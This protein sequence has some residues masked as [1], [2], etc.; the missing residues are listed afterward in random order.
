VLNKFEVFKAFQFRHNKAVTGKM[1]RLRDTRPYESYPYDFPN[2]IVHVYVVDESSAEFPVGL[3]SHLRKVE[4]MMAVLGEIT[5]DLVTSP[6]GATH[7]VVLNGREQEALLIRPGTWH[8]VT[9]PE[10]CILMVMSSTRYEGKDDDF[11][12]VPT[13][14]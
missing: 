14:K 8:K 12:E 6:D 13:G 7:Q 4:I 3:H 1:G 5:I 11:T 9:I 2:G 10:G